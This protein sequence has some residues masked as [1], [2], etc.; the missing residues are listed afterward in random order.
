MGIIGFISSRIR[1]GHLESLC[2]DKR[3]LQP[4]PG[5]LKSM[6]FGTLDHGR[7][8]RVGFFRDHIDAGVDLR[9]I[10]LVGM[11]VLNRR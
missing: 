8:H 10:L 1:W 7:D 4:R 3:D 11:I 9:R 2:F 5:C 6:R